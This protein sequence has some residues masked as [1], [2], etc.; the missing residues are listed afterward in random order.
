MKKDE[1]ALKAFFAFAKEL[2]KH[3]TTFTQ[4][5][6][7]IRQSIVQKSFGMTDEELSVAITNIGGDL[8]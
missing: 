3:T 6:T 8:E 4:F 1:A 2:R 5:D 7:I